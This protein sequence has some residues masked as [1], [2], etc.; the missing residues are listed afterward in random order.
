MSGRV[1]VTSGGLVM[2]TPKE[3]RRQIEEKKRETRELEEVLQSYGSQR[4]VIARA[5]A[6]ADALGVC[7]HIHSVGPDGEGLP[8]EVVREARS[9]TPTR[10]PICVGR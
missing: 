4:E 2:T 9:Y 8:V 5:R 10:V 7:A 6:R 3:I 1:A